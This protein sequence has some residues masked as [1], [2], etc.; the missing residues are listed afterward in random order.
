MKGMTPGQTQR[1][2][3]GTL[4]FLF[5]DHVVQH[6]WDGSH[7]IVGADSGGST[8]VHN[9]KGTAFKQNVGGNP[10]WKDDVV[11]FA[12]AHDAVVAGELVHR[13]SYHG[14]ETAFPCPR[15]SGLIKWP[16]FLPF[17]LMVVDGKD[18]RHHRY[19]ERQARLRDICQHWRVHNHV[20]DW[21]VNRSYTTTEPGWVEAMEEEAK[22]IGPACEGFVL[23]HVDGRYVEG[24]SPK[25]IRLRCYG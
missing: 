3:L 14:L 24:D 11:R 1:G 2:T 19:E 21:I 22:H 20:R 6:K 13:S 5:G 12:A 15:G 4:R 16:V 9:K 23:K 25:I 18:I 10:G 17:D 8:F 7:L